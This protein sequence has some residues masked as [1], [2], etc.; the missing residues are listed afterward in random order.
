MFLFYARVLIAVGIGWP[1]HLAIYVFAMFISC[2]DG[3]IVTTVLVPNEAS[4]RILAVLDRD[5][6][7]YQFNE[8]HIPGTRVILYQYLPVTC[9]HQAR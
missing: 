5:G 8:E 3:E 7:I 9:I 4:A 1:N 2:L 6:W